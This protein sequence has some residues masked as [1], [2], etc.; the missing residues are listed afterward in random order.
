MASLLDFIFGKGTLDKAAGTSTPNPG[1]PGPNADSAG[2]QLAAQAQQAAKAA[3]VGND[4]GIGARSVT[5]PTPGNDAA[6]KARVKP[7]PV[8]KPQGND[9]AL[10]ARMGP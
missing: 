6:L 2:L 7:M 4:A 5:P 8:V 9:T 3:G 10:K 1:T